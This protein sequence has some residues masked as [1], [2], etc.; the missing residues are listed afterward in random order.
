MVIRKPV[1]TASTS[2]IR[3]NDPFLPLPVPDSTDYLI[4]NPYVEDISPWDVGGQERHSQKATVNRGLQQQPSYTGTS[5]SSNAWVEEDSSRREVGKP[6]Q[7]GPNS[8]S[9]M[10]NHGHD[11][12]PSTLRIGSALETPRTSSESQRLPEPKVP[13]QPELPQAASTHPLQST[14]PYHRART[15]VHSNAEVLHSTEDSSVD[16]WAELSS[17]PPQPKSAPPPPPASSTPPE[18][19]DETRSTYNL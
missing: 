16:V 14:N 13:S 10:Q 8:E 11:G 6:R 2:F 7:P 12:L 9:T 19:N 4:G 3:Q 17:I 1:P 18:Q 15:S 5:D